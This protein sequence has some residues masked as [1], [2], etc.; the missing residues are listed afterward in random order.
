[1]MM[2]RMEVSRR[3]YFCPTV[4]AAY[5][6][7]A[8]R[9]TRSPNPFKSPLM[10]VCVSLQDL[11]RASIEYSHVVFIVAPKHAEE[12]LLADRHAVMMTLALGQYLQV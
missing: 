6:R 5:A 10:S 3:C 12:P 8:E 7:C 2:M 1:M 4:T 11:H 9:R